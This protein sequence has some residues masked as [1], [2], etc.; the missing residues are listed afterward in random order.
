MSAHGTTLL[1]LM[2]TLCLLG[3]LL[4]AAIP[5]VDRGLDRL[6]V[7][8]ARDELGAGIRTARAAA[9]AHGG[10]A[11]VLDVAY[12]RYV[13]VGAAGDTVG[14]PVDLGERHGV[15]L[16][17][18]GTT[19]LITLTFDGLGIGRMASRTVSVRRGVA[20]ARLTVSAYGRVRCW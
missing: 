9:G 5:P 11:M 14:R 15:T 19:N 12:S 6:A 1:E 3:I 16:H 20:E 8:A 18:P 2:I 13:I 17:V 7:L 10:A 4:G